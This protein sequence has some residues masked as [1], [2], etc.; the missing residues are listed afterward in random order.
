MSSSSCIPVAT[1]GFD[2]KAQQLLEIF[3]SSAAKGVYVLVDSP[4]KA[5]ITLFDMDYWQAREMWQQYRQQYPQLPTIVQSITHN[6]IA[7]TL[8]LKKPVKLDQLLKALEKA[9]ELSVNSNS[10][11]AHAGTVDC[12]TRQV[13]LQSEML[14]EKREAIYKELCGRNEN[15]DLNNEIEW[16]KIFYDPSVHLQSFIQQAYQ[17][18]LQRKQSVLLENLNVPML[19]QAHENLAFYCSELND[20]KLNTMMTLPMYKSRVKLKVLSDAEL[21]Q[22]LSSQKLVAEAAEHF[23]WKTALCTARG[24]LPEGTPL[25]KKIA[26][27]RWPN[28]PRLIVTPYSLQIS[29]FLL[30]HPQTLAETVKQLGIPQR[31]VFAFYSAANA[32]GIAFPDRRE[33]NAEQSAIERRLPT[34][35]NSF[36]GPKGLLGRILA[37]LRGTNAHE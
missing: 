31:Y 7:G 17:L 15:I 25:Y 14:V 8:F 34:L 16:G 18:S 36:L 23:I 1:I 6:E 21:D 33:Q 27:I 32:L 13:K 22:Y 35:K 11:T 12:S 30:D 4:D 26:L 9:R 29:A 20:I 37:H 2:K 24:R 3:F 19:I 28:F 5:Q 10:F